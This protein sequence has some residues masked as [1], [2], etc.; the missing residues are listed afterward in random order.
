MPI[1]EDFLLQNSASAMPLRSCRLDC[2][3]FLADPTVARQRG[4]CL[5]GDTVTNRD[6]EMSGCLTRLRN[7]VFGD[8][9]GRILAFLRSTPTMTHAQ[10]TVS[11]FRRI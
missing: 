11:V 6:H 9:A 2:T 7:G 1:A 4:T 3:L 10:A 5:Q 8:H